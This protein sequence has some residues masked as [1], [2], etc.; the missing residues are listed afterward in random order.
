MKRSIILR[1]FDVSGSMF[2]VQWFY[3]G[4]GTLNINMLNPI[5]L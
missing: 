5:Y 2:K 1:K 4:H 3:L